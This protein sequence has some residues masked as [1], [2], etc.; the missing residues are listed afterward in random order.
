MLIFNPEGGRD[1]QKGMMGVLGIPRDSKKGN[2]EGLGTPM[3][4]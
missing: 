4:S 2:D 1:A 3:N